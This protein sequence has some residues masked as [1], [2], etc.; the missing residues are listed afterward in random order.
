MN[1]KT[2]IDR[3]MKKLF[4]FLLFDKIKLEVLNRRKN[5]NEMPEILGS[6]IYY[7]FTSESVS[8][9]RLV[10][11]K[12]PRVQVIRREIRYKIIIN[13]MVSKAKNMKRKES[14]LDSCY[15]IV[16]N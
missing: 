7:E 13:K 10:R 2:P 11:K 12:V 14:K 4:L 6:Q 1:V 16:C 5:L 9:Y 15:L 8:A 3:K